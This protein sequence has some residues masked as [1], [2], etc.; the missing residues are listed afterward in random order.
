M[1]ETLVKELEVCDCIVGLEAN[2]GDEMNYDDTLNVPE[3]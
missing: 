3:F 1:A 2:F